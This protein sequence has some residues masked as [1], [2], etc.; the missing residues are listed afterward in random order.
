VAWLRARQN[1]DG[2][3]GETVASY[4]DEK[5]AG[6]GESTPSQTAWALL[7]LLAADGPRSEAVERGVDYLVRTQ[8]AEGTW[9][10]RLWTG[11]GFPGHFYLRYHLYRHYFPLMALGQYRAR[12]GAGGQAA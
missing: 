7:G 9:A 3:W 2:G 11:T 6:K 5:L 12:L 10:E 4:D 8:N 1:P